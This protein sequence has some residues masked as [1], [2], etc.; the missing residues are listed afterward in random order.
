LLVLEAWTSPRSR[1]DVM[2]INKV[3]LHGATEAG[4]S[5]GASAGVRRLV[6]RYLE[7]SQQLYRMVGPRVTLLLV[8]SIPVGAVLGIVEIVTATL[9]NAVLAEFGLTS[10]VPARSILGLDPVAALLFFTTCAGGLRY[11]GQ[12]LPAFANNALN[13]RLREVLVDNVLGGITERSA[14]SVADASLL[15]STIIPKSGDFVHGLTAVAVGF[16]SVMLVLAGMVYLSWQ[17]SAIV[18]GFILAL[19]LLL[20]V[21]RHA[22][23]RHIEQMYAMFADFNTAF[24]RDVRNAH[25]LRICGVNH[26][27]AQRLVKLS[28]EHIRSFRNYFLLF[29]ASSN[30][31][32]V[33]AI[34][35]LIGIFELNRKVELLSMDGLIPLVYLLSR[36]GTSVGTL[37]TASGMVRQNRPWITQMVRHV[38]ELFPDR[39]DTTV[40]QEEPA[41]LVPFVVTEL[42]FGR[43]TAFSPPISLIAGAGDTVLISGPSGRGK[44][45]LL[46]TIIGLVD[47]LGGGVT[48]GGVPL[49][50]IDPVRL[51]R[52]VGYAGAE[53]YLIDEDVRTNLLFGCQAARVSDSDIEHALRLACA[54]F[55]FDLDG[56]LSHRLQEAGD[57]I[58]AGQKQRLAIARCLLRR[59]DVL[60]LDEAT[61]NIDEATERQIMERVRTALPHLLIICVSHR[62]SMRG[63]ATKSLE[64]GQSSEVF[65]D[66]GDGTA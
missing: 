40:G 16:G 30:I 55:V 20:A 11:I 61:A 26:A 37:A 48:W 21:I 23:G 65:A 10:G 15:L 12:F 19:G 13:A 53:P 28:Q 25:L 18:L 38:P 31:P 54:E 4:R 57:G 22:Y 49:E 34:F 5:I 39:F 51:R 66:S 27:E 3:V 45:T 47:A 50:R 36:V 64:I 6:A 7:R 44:T 14:K 33:A 17:L 8:A 32:A 52:R 63:Y 1:R 43:G 35:L 2:L 60:L 24:I 62:A 41:T 58:S 9:L 46:L 56:G 29:A 42:E 59:P